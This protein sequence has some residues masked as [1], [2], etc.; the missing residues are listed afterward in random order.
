MTIED[1][2]RAIAAKLT[3]LWPGSQVFVDEIPRQA[4]GNLFIGLIDSEQRRGLGLRRERLYQF[5]VLYFL[6][7]RKN[8]DFWAWAESMYQHFDELTVDTGA[9]ARV[10]H[11]TGQAA[12]SDDDN[13]VYQ[14]MFNAEIMGVHLPEITDPMEE[15]QYEEKVKA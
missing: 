5:E 2:I 6:R 13:R 1:L 7:S 12:R 11:L 10:V 4:D 15:L 8:M 9:G 14:F 3:A